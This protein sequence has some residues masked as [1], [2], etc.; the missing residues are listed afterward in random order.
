M[1]R[2]GKMKLLPNKGNAQNGN[3]NLHYILKIQFKKIYFKSAVYLHVGKALNNW[4][5]P[6]SC[7]CQDNSPCFT[8]AYSLHQF[9]DAGGITTAV[10]HSHCEQDEVWL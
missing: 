5:G 7:E 4:L 2:D 3:R 8:R 9:V 10:I 1:Q 6:I